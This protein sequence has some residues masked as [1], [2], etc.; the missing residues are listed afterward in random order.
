MS[1]L[2]SARLHLA[3][4]DSGLHDLTQVKV[5]KLVPHH[6]PDFFNDQQILQNL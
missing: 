1:P 2:T 4:S 5:Q 6:D 3:F